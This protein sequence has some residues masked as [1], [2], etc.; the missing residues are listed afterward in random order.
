MDA[1]GMH[2][3][4][5]AL[6]DTGLLSG[7]AREWWRMVRCELRWK[8]AGTPDCEVF[9]EW[10][11]DIGLENH[12]DIEATTNMAYKCEMIVANPPP[13]DHVP[14]MEDVD[15]EKSSTDQNH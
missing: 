15:N 2:Y 7:E 11:S 6:M 14:N 12:T 3:L 10:F 8:G 1:L 9:H 5:H 13:Q 4:D